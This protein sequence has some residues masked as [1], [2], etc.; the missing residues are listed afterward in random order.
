MPTP[1]E[2]HQEPS[3]PLTPQ[4]GPRPAGS[5]VRR[6]IVE[7]LEQRPDEGLTAVELAGVL[8]V[9]T[10][11]ARFHLDQLVYRHTLDAAFERRGVGRP[12]K[13][14]RLSPGRA[15]VALPEQQASSLGLLTGLLTEMV[16][17]QGSRLTTPDEAGQR[18]AAAN[19]R[20]DAPAT[21]ARTQ[22]EWLHKVRSLMHVLSSWGYGPTVTA[23]A[24]DREAE[25]V[26]THCPFRDL[27]KANPDVVCGIHRG[28]IRGSM[29]GLGEQ[30]TEVDLV[31]FAQGG[32][33][34][35]AHLYDPQSTDVPPKES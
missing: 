7:E 33:A 32:D 24:T 17:S 29:Q 19:V 8:G 1:S 15:P 18:W 20:P 12:R 31:P 6:R 22:R 25:I 23:H 9:H 3:L 27:A 16:A 35:I 11:T 26:L 10:S 14:Y 28:L 21:P 4:A 13:V 34:C 30:H 5:A 2:A